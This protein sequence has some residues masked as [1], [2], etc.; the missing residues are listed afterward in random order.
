MVVVTDVG[1]NLVR[2][3]LVS[4]LERLLETL[5][6]L[7]RGWKR[8]AEAQRLALV[9]ARADA[10]VGASAR[11][12]V[13]RGGGLD[14][15]ARIAVDDAGHQRAEL[16]PLRH[17]GQVAQGA[18]ALEHRLLGL[19]DDAYLEEVVHDPQARETGLVRGPADLGQFVAYPPVPVRPG[20]A[21]NL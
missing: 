2:P 5:E 10:E 17:P 6:S 4:D 21:G 11:E 18:V 1:L 7:L 20:E 16:R 3:H 15:E 14:E 19:A 13:E 8:H 12:H 9:P